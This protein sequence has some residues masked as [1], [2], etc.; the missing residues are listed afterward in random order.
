MWHVCRYPA[1]EE[2]A[3]V[4]QAPVLWAL[5]LSSPDCHHLAVLSNSQKRMT[6]YRERRHRTAIWEGVV[7]LPFLSVV[8][9]LLVA[10]LLLAFSRLPPAAAAFLLPD[11]DAV[12]SPGSRRG[13]FLP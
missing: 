9:A 13:F 6:P 12:L 1:A 7:A 4:L 8:V 5:E 11:V 2:A 3:V 10:L